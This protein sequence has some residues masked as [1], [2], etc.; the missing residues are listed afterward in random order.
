[1]RSVEGA[2]MS[3]KGDIEPLTLDTVIEQLISI[4]LWLDRQKYAAP[5]IDINQAI[6]KLNGIHNDGSSANV[7]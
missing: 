6:E 5:A 7:T 1:M 2:A 3:K 4:L